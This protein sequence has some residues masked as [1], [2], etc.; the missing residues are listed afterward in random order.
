MRYTLMF[1]W[2]V[3]SSLAIQSQRASGQSL[4]PRQSAV[5]TQTTEISEEVH[6]ATSFT[7]VTETYSSISSYFVETSQTLYSQTTTI[8]E[9]AYTL[10]Q[11]Q[12]RLYTAVEAISGGCNCPLDGLDTETIQTTIVTWFT[13]L[14]YMVQIIQQRYPRRYQS[15][16]G[17]TFTRIST[18]LQVA[19]GV[20]YASG[21][22]IDHIVSGAV[23]QANINPTILSSVHIQTSSFTQISKSVTS[24]TGIFAN[25]TA[26]VGL[27]FPKRLGEVLR[28]QNTTSRHVG[29]SNGINGLP[30]H[31]HHHNKTLSVESG[32]RSDNVSA[33]RGPASDR[34]H[35]NLTTPIAAVPN[36]PTGGSSNSTLP[37][38]SGARPVDG[39]DNHGPAWD[40]KHHRPTTPITAVPN[41]LGGGSS[42]S[43]LPVGS[44][45]RPV[46]GS[47]NRGPAWDRKPVNPTTPI[48]AVP[49]SPA[50]E[51]SKS[52]FPVDDHRFP[53]GSGASPISTPATGDS[54]PG[55]QF[56]GNWNHFPNLPTSDG[57]P[58]SSGAIGNP[59]HTTFP[60]ET[61]GGG[62]SPS[63]RNGEQGVKPEPTYN[64]IPETNP[65]PSARK[66][67]S[68]HS[69]NPVQASSP[70]SAPRPSLPSFN[71][72]EGKPHHGAL[73]ESPGNNVPARSSN[74]ATNP[75][76]AP[77]RPPTAAPLTP[78]P[79][80]PS[81]SA[82]EPGH[83][84]HHKDDQN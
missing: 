66:P 44:S 6:I 11:F 56:P 13:Q 18:H 43:T 71:G 80:T 10:T 61:P 41:P 27:R 76:Q 36:L 53:P 46:D 48:A 9:A 69:E 37:V 1:F 70:W 15:Y 4:L 63:V 52:P 16:F 51:S 38:G 82:P 25:A 39:S 21:V 78:P 84:G 81:G 8:Q 57:K 42:N 45:P 34:K 19:L 77:P 59:I 40:R 35:V 58:T 12:E 26:P 74:D 64:R 55:H 14:Q 22:D 49:N 50:G 23:K 62:A 30:K 54:K 17:S 33:I 60:N 3:A 24:Q 32:L 31:G 79:G 83:K 67:D 7:Q 72:F 75:G 65:F 2:A 20:A 29:D 28:A 68:T 73:V 47:D 5:Q